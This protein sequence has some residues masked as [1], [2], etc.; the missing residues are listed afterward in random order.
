MNLQGIF[1]VDLLGVAFIVWIVNLVRVRRLY[2]GYAILW[3][4]ACLAVIILVSVPPLL[5]LVTRTVGALFPAS[6]LSL[7]AFAFVF[8]VLILFS[9]QLSGLKDRQARLARSLALFEL[10]EQSRDSNVASSKEGAGL[11][12]RDAGQGGEN[13]AE[14]SVGL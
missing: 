7:I 3:L 11:E 4:S 8:A 12:D 14:I 2:A 6:A 10:G 5:H 13:G 1:V 9:V